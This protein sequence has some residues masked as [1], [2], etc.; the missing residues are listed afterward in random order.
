MTPQAAQAMY[1]ATHYTAMRDG[2]TP[3][4]YYKQENI[5]F[6]DKTSKLCWVYLSYANIW[7]GSGITKE[8]EHLLIPII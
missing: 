6:N 2:V 4:M 8:Q 7:M 3:Q 1:G 5:H